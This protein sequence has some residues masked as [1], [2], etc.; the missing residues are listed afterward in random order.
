[1]FNLCDLE[2]DTDYTDSC[3]ATFGDVVVFLE[4]KSDAGELSL[5]EA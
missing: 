1:L 5:T 4:D 2:R 3:P